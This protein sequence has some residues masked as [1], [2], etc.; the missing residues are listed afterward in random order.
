MGGPIGFADTGRIDSDGFETGLGQCV[1]HVAPGVPGLRPAR[2]QQHRLT[3]A[4]GH[5]MHTLAVDA[6]VVVAQGVVAGSAGG[7]GGSHGGRLRWGSGD[8]EHLLHLCG[9]DRRT[10]EVVEDLVGDRDDVHSHSSVAQP[11]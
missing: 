8:A 2:N 7:K 9:A 5:A 3:V 6:Q 4:G 10:G 1:Q 11:A